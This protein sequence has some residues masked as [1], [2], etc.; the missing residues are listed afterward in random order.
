MLRLILLVEG[1]KGSISLHIH[2]TTGKNVLLRNTNTYLGFR[3]RKKGTGSPLPL[4][5]HRHRTAARIH[6]VYRK[7]FVCLH[8][9]HDEINKYYIFYGNFHVFWHYI[10]TFPNATIHPRQ[11][12]ALQLRNIKQNGNP[13]NI[14]QCETFK[15]S[16]LSIHRIHAITGYNINTHTHVFYNNRKDRMKT[17]LSNIW[18]GDFLFFHSK[19][20]LFGSGGSWEK[21]EG[22]IWWYD[23]NLCQQIL[24]FFW[25]KWKNCIMKCNT[26]FFSSFSWSRFSI[27]C[28]Y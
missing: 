17:K 18:M 25:F 26:I 5:R 4:C 21:S 24:R 28:L 19:Q 23:K 13:H 6:L 10:I 12:C 16:V 1:T 15:D 3:E 2:D 14:M 7:Y 8:K 11:P 22:H 9:D 20:N 27:S